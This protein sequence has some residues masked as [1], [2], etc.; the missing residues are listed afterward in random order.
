MSAA[1]AL[2]VNVAELLRRP[3]TRRD[4]R[5]GVHLADLSVIDSRVPA[6]ADV[7]VDLV[8]ES[9]PDGVVATGAVEAPWEGV[10]RRCL[11]PVQGLVRTPVREVF[12][13]Q[14][15]SEDVFPLTGDRVD[16]EPLVRE[17][18]LLELPLAPLCREDCAGL[19]PTCG[20]DRNEA[21][22][23]HVGEAADQ[24]WSAL[25]ELRFDADG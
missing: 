2:R 11:R 6:E 13:A 23:G 21:D 10:C 20:A 12:E 15:V 24:R 8:L 16:L 18:V 19:C 14:P 3:G 4:V 9:L 17:A 1:G 5:A 7:D 22:C 25:G